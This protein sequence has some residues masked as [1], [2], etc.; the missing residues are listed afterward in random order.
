M[1]QAL[2]LPYGD[3]RVA[4]VL[5]RTN[6]D[7]RRCTGIRTFDLRTGC[8]CTWHLEQFI[9]DYTADPA[10]LLRERFPMGEGDVDPETLVRTRCRAEA[11]AAI[12][13][14]QWK[15]DA[16]DALIGKLMALGAHDGVIG[17]MEARREAY[18]E[19]LEAKLGEWYHAK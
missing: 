11:L 14:L 18:R 2:G 10:A 1:R 15:L 8:T 17:L 3:R 5:D 7:W 4:E 12:E 9:H 19:D 16:F 13:T 6:P